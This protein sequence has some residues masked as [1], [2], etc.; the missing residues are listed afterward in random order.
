M[1][2]NP[3]TLKFH[4]RH[5]VLTILAL[6]IGGQALNTVPLTLFFQVD[7]IFGSFFTLLICRIYG[8][9]AAVLSAIV[10]SL[11]TYWL[12][13]HPYAIAIF[14]LEAAVAGLL[15]KRRGVLLPLADA[16]Y[17]LI[18]GMPLVLLFYRGA[19][20]LP[21]DGS[22]LIMLKQALNGILNA[23]LANVAYLAA[24][25]FARS[26]GA[27]TSRPPLLE[28]VFT[29]GST[30]TLIPALLFIVLGSRSALTQVENSVQEQL[31]AAL[32][33]ASRHISYIYQRHLFA[34][35][36]LAGNAAEKFSD[37]AFLQQQCNSIRE[38]F[39]D[40]L[41]V[42]V[43]DTTATAVAFSPAT[44]AAGASNIGANFSHRE[45]FQR[46]VA[47]QKPVISAAVLGR[48]IHGPI[49]TI[50]VP[51]F[52]NAT[53]A[54]YVSGALNLSY[55]EQLL[56]RPALGAIEVTLLDSKNRVLASTL[57]DAEPLMEYTN[58][59]RGTFSTVRSNLYMRVP[60]GPNPVM[61]RWAQSF[62]GHRTQLDQSWPVAVVAEM[63]VGPIQAQLYGA[64]LQNLLA[65][66]GSFAFAAL[67][68]LVLTRALSRP[69]EQLA[70]VTT[71]ITPHRAS[72]PAWPVCYT[73]ELCALTDNF[74]KAFATVQNSIQTLNHRSTDLAAKNQELSGEIARRTEVEEGL[75]RKE[76]L[77]QNYNRVM[78]RLSREH[79]LHAELV[80]YFK[81]I[82]ERAARALEVERC[83]IWLFDADHSR[84]VCHDLFQ[85]SKN[86][87]SVGEVL[88]ATDFPAYFNA[89]T[90][91]RA[92]AASDAAQDPRTRE[93]GGL[94]LRQHGIASMLDA[95]I[96]LEGELIGIVCHEHVGTPRIWTPEEESF[97][98][99]IADFAALCVQNHQRNAALNALR[100]SEARYRTLAEQLE[101]QVAER[102]EHLQKSVSELESFCYSVS[103]DLRAPLR[104]MS[105]YSEF[106][107]DDLPDLDA[108]ARGYLQGIRDSA[109]KMD[110]LIND[111]LEYSRL[112][113]AELPSRSVDPAA[114]VDRAMQSLGSIIAE[115]NARIERPS[116]YP[117]V[118]ANPTAL[119][120]IFT[121]LIGNALKFVPKDQVPEIRIAVEQRDQRIIFSIRDN[122]IGIRPE[123][124]EKIFGLFQRLHGA[125]EFEGTGVGLAI[126]RRAL[127]RMGGRVWLESEPGQ[128]STFFFELPK[129]RGSTSHSA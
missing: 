27:Q 105:G 106:L 9:G 85:F 55:L 118:L 64:Y 35:E 3:P 13:G 72:E 46:L 90:Q 66:L 100:E 22:I 115:R 71:S 20:N 58:L 51:I 76:R 28:W 73:A 128:G 93:F 79:Q 29:G 120:Q 123:H 122:G 112:S 1:P 52:T 62:Y 48:N 33:S 16:I 6:S 56:D 89:L 63:P 83:S 10:T 111:L 21:W 38:L 103:H 116:A 125:S 88:S 53:L 26:G 119:D 108:T 41:G 126:V 74:R 18:L 101:T 77:L 54:G 129:D 75:R 81:P 110:R 45:Y 49:Q 7:F 36:Q 5:P 2:E 121:N 67:L 127:D 50:N 95:P 40:Y 39:P 65:G 99:S 96:R 12:W 102:T 70:E 91:Q 104:A 17:W 59:V 109:Q 47:T 8:P 11:P 124:A 92:I 69:I 25:R 19:M 4:R 24:I 15:H 61:T 84:I 78:V 86:A 31:S 80:D 30:L 94:Y 114:A 113:N 34:V 32:E 87:H 117:P 42:Y 60:V 37:R 68:A 98:G 44:N 57:D 14:T 82:T 97:A 43:G 23:L 107:I